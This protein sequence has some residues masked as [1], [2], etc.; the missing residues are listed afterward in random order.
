MCRARRAP[1]WPGRKL[2]CKR[3]AAIARKRFL[4]MNRRH[5]FRLHPTRRNP[6]WRHQPLLR[7]PPSMTKKQVPQRWHPPFLGGNRVRRRQPAPSR[8]RRVRLLLPLTTLRDVQSPS[9]RTLRNERHAQRDPSHLDRL[10]EGCRRA[11]A[12]AP[13]SGEKAP[14][15]SLW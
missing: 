14:T 7:R 12:T 8:R 1:R 9:R 3:F 13:T 10:G 6:P 11:A 2:S 4:Q 5:R 15:V